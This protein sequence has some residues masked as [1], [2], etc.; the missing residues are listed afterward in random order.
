M[1]EIIQKD[2]KGIMLNE[3]G[4]YTERYMRSLM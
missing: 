2:P 1:H 4:K 3:Q